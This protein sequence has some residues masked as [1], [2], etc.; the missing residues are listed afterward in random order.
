M[1]KECS[2]SVITRNAKRLT[3]HCWPKLQYGTCPADLA[4]LRAL[5]I[6]ISEGAYRRFKN[7]V[8]S[9]A[10]LKH[11]S[12]CYR[13]TRARPTSKPYRTSYGQD[14]NDHGRSDTSR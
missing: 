13:R 6:D 9:C 2:I 5:S 4:S 7:V 1:P 8:V 10:V 12:R 11:W 14:G 3:R